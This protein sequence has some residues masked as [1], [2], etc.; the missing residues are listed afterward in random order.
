MVISF[1]IVLH[2]FGLKITPQGGVFVNEVYFLILIMQR[3][4][5]VLCHYALNTRNILKVIE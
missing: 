4:R 2:Q 5:T 3:N 1:L